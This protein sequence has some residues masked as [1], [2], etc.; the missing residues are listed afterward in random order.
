MIRKATSAAEVRSVFIDRAVREQWSSALD[1]HQVFYAT[2][3][4]GFFVGELNGKA[5]S[6]IS[7]VEYSDKYGF[8]GFY[9]VDKAYRDKGYGLALTKYALSQSRSHNYGLSG[10]LD[11]VPWYEKIGFETAWTNRRMLLDVSHC[12]SCLEKF[13]IP[14]NVLIKPAK[15]VNF[16]C[17]S[18]YDTAAFGAPHHLF[19]KALL[20]AS[21]SISLAATNSNNDIIGFISGRKTILENEGWKIAPLFADNSLIAKALL[22]QLFTELAKEDSKRKVAIMDVPVDLNPNAYRL[23]QELSGTFRFDMRQMFTKGAIDVEADKIFGMASVEL[24]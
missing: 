13:E 15:Q 4:N 3:P 17:L 10:V 6:C 24:G 7:A 11:K 5:I 2:D 14:S 8:F 22:K 18:A 23:V 9:V 1:D 21:N 20:N 19:L 12:N 16:N